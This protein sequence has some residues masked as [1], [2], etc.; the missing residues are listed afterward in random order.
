MLKSSNYCETAP[1][2]VQRLLFAVGYTCVHGHRGFALHLAE[3]ACMS[4]VHA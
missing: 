2:N 1:E 3:N 4:G